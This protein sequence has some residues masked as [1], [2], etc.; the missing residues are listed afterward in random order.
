MA[1]PFCHPYRSGPVCSRA[2]ELA[3]PRYCKILLTIV[4]GWGPNL[5]VVTAARHGELQVARLFFQI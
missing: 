2:V 5:E 4:E 3:L 1:F